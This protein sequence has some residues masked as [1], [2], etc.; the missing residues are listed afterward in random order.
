MTFPLSSE[1][2]YP[3]ESALDLEANLQGSRGPCPTSPV[4]PQPGTWKGSKGPE[5][6]RCP[7]PQHPHRE[8][9]HNSLHYFRPRNSD[10]SF[11]GNRT[12]ELSG[13]RRGRSRRP[14]TGSARSGPGC[15]QEAS[16]SRPRPTGPLLAVFAALT[17][18]PNPSGAAEGS[19]PGGRG[20][21]GPHR[22]RRRPG[23]AGEAGSPA[24]GL[25]FNSGD[26]GARRG[27]TLSLTGIS[28]A[29]LFIAKQILNAQP[30]PPESE[31]L[32]MGSAVFSKPPS[33][34]GVRSSLRTTALY[35]NKRLS[36]NKKLIMGELIGEEM[37]LFKTFCYSLFV[38]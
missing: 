22:S 23:L 1:K 29:C 12:R 35:N 16:A 37:D 25:C 32:G 31:T 9:R 34:A 33:D 15:P 14:R 8:A 28:I 11:Q 2:S 5:Q 21:R 4:R 27:L 13:R 17:R 36:S 7:P 30:R 20:T 6:A 26:A 10:V 38:F 24:S 3:R 18:S 19:A